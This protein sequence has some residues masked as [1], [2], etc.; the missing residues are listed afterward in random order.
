MHPVMRVAALLLLLLPA[1]GVQAADHAST[2]GP[3]EVPFDLLSPATSSSTTTLPE[4]TSSAVTVWMVADD[5]LVALQRTV[6]R[7]VTLERVLAALAE[8][9]TEN[10]AALGIRSALTGARMGESADVTADVAI[11]DLVAEF[12]EAAPR[13]QLLALAQLVYTATELPGVAV[14]SFE[15]DGT[16][17]EVPKAD[18]S[19]TD[20]PVTR[21]DYASLASPVS[22]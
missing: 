5:H 2:A 18:G 8:G 16:P 7:P 6:A 14:V 19:L 4:L 10:E 3:E 15:I 22:G 17:I 12:G 11:I 21:A 1:C 20:R 13:E 9:P